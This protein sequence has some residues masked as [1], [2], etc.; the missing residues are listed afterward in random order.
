M[1][2][3]DATRTLLPPEPLSPAE[4]R[5]L[6]YLVQKWPVSTT[7]TPYT[8]PLASGHAEFV[9]IVQTLCDNGLISYEAFLMQSSQGLRYMG[10]TITARGKAALQSMSVAA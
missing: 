2:P 1:G 5:L 7:L 4:A 8:V 3:F 9:D 10:V 6:G